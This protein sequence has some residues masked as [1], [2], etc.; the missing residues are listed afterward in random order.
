MDVQALLQAY[1][2]ENSEAAFQE[3]VNRY[4]DLVFS[5]A[6]RRVGGNR[7]LAE[8]VSQLVFT[9][10]ARKAA[11][12]PN[13]VML[14]GWLHRHT[15]FVASNVLR[16]EQRRRHRER[17]AMEMNA[18]NEPSEA[19]WNQLALVL[20]EAMDQLDSSDRDAVVLRY[21]ERRELRAVGTALGIS[22]DAAQKRVSRAVDKLR[23]LLVNRDATLLPIAALSI[24]LGSRCIQAAPAGLNL[25]IGKSALIAATAGGVGLVA[26]IAN[27]LSPAAA[28]VALLA[29]T[30]LIVAAALLLQSH[31]AATQS[32]QAKAQHSSL[33][34]PK[35][36]DPAANVESTT[37]IQPQVAAK[38]TQTTNGIKLIILAADSSKPVPNVLVDFRGTQNK[39]FKVEKFF[40]DR[41]GNCYIDIP[42]ETISEVELT[43]RVDDF[44]DTRLRWRP[45]HGEEIPAS[46][47]LRL[48]RPV[49]IGG[50]VVDADGQP[51]SG[52]KVGFNHEDDPAAVT[53]PEN[54][55]FS[56]IE[57][58][59]ETNGHWSINRIA[60][61]M[62][63]RIYGSAKHPDHVQSPMVF[64]SREKEAEQQLRA[65]NYVFHV[66]RAV[67]VRGIVLDS[68]GA[69]VPDASILVGKRGMSDSRQGTSAPDGTFDIR[70]CAMGTN[71]LTAEAKEFSA[72]TMEVVFNEDS[73]PFKLMLQRG[74]LLRM[75]VVGQAGEP[76]VGANVWLDTFHNRPFNAPDYGIT[77][78]Q[79][80]FDG[81]TDKTGQMLWSN[82][83][84]S[85]LEFDIAASGYMRKSEIKV[86]P[87]GQEHLITLSPALI[88]SGTVRDA[89]T[90]D[91]IPR[92]KM[93]TGWPQTNW[94]PDPADSAK[95]L[96]KVEGR[97]PTIERYWVNFS[98][99]TYKHVLEEPALYSDPNPG[100]VLKIEAEDYAPFISR[101]IAADEGNVQLDAAMHRA[102][103]RP[104][105]VIL[106]DGS[107]AAGTDIGFVVP[108]SHLHL[109]PGGFS[110]QSGESSTTLL[111][112]D[113][114]G[115]FRLP[116]DPA[117]T[118]V[119]AAN[120]AGYIE[121]TPAAL[122]E[123]P[124]LV[125]QPWGRLE[126][127]CLASGQPA[128]N[129]DLLLQFTD[130]DEAVGISFDFTTFK[131]STDAKGHF[132][133]PQAPPGKLKI[134]HLAHIPP[135]GFSHQPLPDG[136]VE[137]RAGETTTKALGGSG[138]IIKARARWPQEII[139]D[140]KWHFFASA[141]SAPPQAI[142]QAANDPAAL[143]ALQDNPEI[144]AYAQKAV[145]IQ[146]DVTDD[147]SISI[148]NVPQ[149]DYIVSVMA[150]LDAPGE[151]KESVCGYSSVV[152]VPTEPPIGIV[153]AGEVVLKKPAL[154]R[155]R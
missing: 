110:H 10:L 79:A 82:A 72:S 139:P 9:D 141:S 64:A 47:T 7:Q 76:V 12:L 95:L 1:A 31:H 152:T 111:R 93:I 83:P 101:T 58:S 3:L 127:T 30:A 14:G 45:D 19:D 26:G 118:R 145:H 140:N 125:L 11:S 104:I 149:G 119:I 134:I 151:M 57:V 123:N 81:K 122:A 100:Y 97:W 105:S 68:D 16:T 153:D 36:S 143:T 86:H 62:I 17:K 107:P 106:P 25:K 135:N 136:D 51:V 88:I 132:V 128:A 75:R 38:A 8:D 89:E 24:L 18:L 124:V 155:S 56:W 34:Q 28:K 137:I 2:R 138:Y 35:A 43:T 70:G 66:G 15:G 96:T 48:T 65:G 120:P 63:R 112:T 42:R 27:W 115:R 22:D 61:D 77:P 4:L 78:V 55:E 113:P 52:A 20:D 32:P 129:R 29:G 144:Q 150:F 90:G 60:P 109:M 74:K 147:Y 92:F 103:A 33:Q 21:F 142:L 87:D 41:A 85:E 130:H 80:S 84:D 46:Y 148:E 131:A 116:G 73:G 114:G 53:L 94:V 67:T 126:G 6:I 40:A 50:S 99:G 37:T 44:A 133:F 49:A 117:V 54:H 23:E 39:K 71:Y 69:S 102:T 98:G 121:T 108:G 5:T 13:N 59:T 91:L 154:A 146:A